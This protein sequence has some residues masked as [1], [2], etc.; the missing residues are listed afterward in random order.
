[1]ETMEKQGLSLVRIASVRKF[2]DSREEYKSERPEFIQ[3]CLSISIVSGD[4]SRIVH[5]PD[6]LN[7]ALR[8][9]IEL[10]EPE[11]FSLA[12]PIV[13]RREQAAHQPDV[14]RETTP[15]ARSCGSHRSREGRSSHHR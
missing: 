10:R 12:T 14:R 4:S 8:A 2:A 13:G 6:R 5:R 9:A 3:I 11:L 15:G 1:M 7:A